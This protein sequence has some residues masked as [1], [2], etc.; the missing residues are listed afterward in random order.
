MPVLSEQQIAGLDG[1][2]EDLRTL[3]STIA[4]SA[5]ALATA[6][7]AARVT[8][9]ADEQLPEGVGEQACHAPL[10]DP[11]PSPGSLIGAKLGRAERQIL[12]VLAQHG[13]RST[14][15]VALLTGR[16]Y[17]G[18]GFRN[19]LSSLRSAGLIE[20][21]A[22]V[23]ITD[24][25]RRELGTWD[26]LPTPGPELVAWWASR[27]D[28]AP[29]LILEHLA[30]NPDRSIPINEIAEATGYSPAGGGFRNALSRLRSLDLAHGR[31]ELRINAH[32]L[33]A[34]AAAS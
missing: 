1:A 31:S 25:G 12:T 18:G 29:R 4:A 19:A 10:D 23:E 27:L 21:R 17:K 30:A 20:G 6:L 11:T 26:T 22:E 9:T 14:S 33:I 5:D 24:M 2:V 34:A 28:K 15:Q 16:S 3:A 7:S 32:L 8:E 13:R